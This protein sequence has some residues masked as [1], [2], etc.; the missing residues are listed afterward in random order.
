MGKLLKVAVAGLGRMG[1]VH[2]RHLYELASERHGCEL[3]A[4]ADLDIERGRRF[5]AEVGSQVPIF[6]SVEE[7]A[8]AGVCDAAVIVTPTENHRE[9]AAML[10]AAGHRVL[11]RSR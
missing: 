9:H 8:K 1:A 2:A 11:L 7:L 6:R 4:L 10:I 3:A 5:N